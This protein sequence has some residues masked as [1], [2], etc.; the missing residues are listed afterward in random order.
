MNRDPKYDVL[1]TPIKVGPKILKN[2]F[3]ATPQCTGFGSDRPGQQAYHRAMKAAGGFAIVHTEWAAIHPEADEWPAITARIWDDDDARNLQLMVDK[4]HEH[5]ALAGIQLGFNGSGSENLETRIAARGVEQV[6]SDTFTF[7][8][9]YTMT[10]REIRELRRF[11]VQAARRA[12]AVGFDVINF[13]VN[14]DCTVIQQFLMPRYNN[15]T[16]EYG[17]ATM[18]NRSRFLLEV[19][20]QV[21]EAVHDACAVTVRL[22]I[23]TL[24]GG[25]RGIDADETAPA[26]VELADHLVDLWDMEVCGPIMQ[27][28]GEAAGSSRFLRQGYQLPYV[29]KVRPY[30]KKPIV[31]VGRFVDPD[32]MVAAIRSGVIDL[33]GMARPGI[34]DP[35]L[36]TKI[37]EGRTDEIRECIG[38]NICVSR[39]EQHTSIICTQNPTIGEEYRRG[40]HPELF[41]LA[42][43]R[44]S[45]ILV[46]GAGPAGLEAAVVLARR[47]LRAVHLVDRRR[48]MGGA[49]NWIRT[50]P[51]LGEWGWVVD[52]RRTQL[53]KLR[54]VEFIGGQDLSPAAVLDYG[55]DIVVVATGSHWATDGLNGT[56]HEPIPGADARLPHILTPEQLMVEGKT[57]SGE[58]VL[59]Y[60]TDG[61]F[62]GVSLAEKLAREGKRVTYVTSFPEVAP[63]MVYTLENHRQV[64]LLHQLGVETVPSHV[65]TAIQ[66]G[67]VTGYRVYAEWRPVSWEA[68]TVVL[69]TMRVSDDGLYRALEANQAALDQAAI[70][71]LYRIG[72]CVVPRLIADAIFDGHRLAREI[73]TDNPAVPLPFI[74]ERRVLGWTDADYDRVV[75]DQGIDWPV[76]S[77]LSKP[78]I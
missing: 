58:R 57:I 53:D 47:G 71:G 48:E 66:P 7:H 9:C 50:L 70:T 26:I 35:F 34:A 2:R 44:D 17:P 74:R 38:C 28:W 13:C 45:G 51:G 55:A 14:E 36:P 73:D 62:M 21:R 72:D 19:V 75:N 68:D 43:N 77:V 64:R 61:Y 3:Y 76:S 42:R 69:V 46:V 78:R 31:N 63:Y 20:E 40:W 32:A 65:V 52:D 56:T 24:D 8:S 37:A 6:P 41:S 27:E 12:R 39:Y 22:A 49:L 54:N 16:D 18:E 33:I 59:V 25:G 5:G 30:T 23:D 1:F 29:A 4:V 15:R 10:K 11:Y 67:L 60:D